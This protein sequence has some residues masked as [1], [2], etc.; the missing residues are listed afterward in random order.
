MTTKPKTN[1][2]LLAAVQR[3]L[4]DRTDVLVFLAP[5]DSAELLCMQLRRVMR[6]QVIAPDSF[7]PYEKDEW[8]YYAQPIMIDTRVGD[9]LLARQHDT[10]QFNELMGVEMI[11]ARD[12]SDVVHGLWRQEMWSDGPTRPAK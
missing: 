5:D 7:S 4:E 6:H 8:H 2:K 10:R 12:M 3:Y 1:H 11:F 9:K